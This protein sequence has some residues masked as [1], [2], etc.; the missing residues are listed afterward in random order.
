MFQLPVQAALTVTVPFRSFSCKAAGP[1]PWLCRACVQVSRMCLPGGLPWVTLAPALY[2]P[3]AA[4]Q[5]AAVGL[6]F[7]HGPVPMDPA[8]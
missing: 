6:G 5:T 1:S 3:V 2:M 8:R 4:G 7:V